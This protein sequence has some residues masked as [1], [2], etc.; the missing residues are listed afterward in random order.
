MR[1]Q[2]WDVLLFPE[3][4]HVPLKEFKTTCYAVQSSGN[5]EYSSS[6]YAGVHTVTPL[7][8]TFVPGIPMNHSFTISVHA[9]VPA[10][11]PEVNK[12]DQLHKRYKWQV[13]VLINGLCVS[14]QKI[15]AVVT[16][17]QVIN[18]GSPGH[19]Y[20]MPLRFPPF[21]RATG[22][23]REWDPAADVGR[24]KVELSAGYDMYDAGDW[25]FHKLATTA[26]F[27]FY[28]APMDHLEKVGIAW[29]SK[30]MFD[31]PLHIASPATPRSM[32]QDYGKPSDYHRRSVSH[33]SIGMSLSPSM[34]LPH[35][36]PPTPAYAH[37]LYQSFSQD[38]HSNYDLSSRSTSAHSNLGLSGAAESLSTGLKDSYTVGRT[39]QVEK[40]R[41]SSEQMSR[42][43]Q[44]LGPDQ[45]QQLTQSLTS[46][47]AMPPPPLPLHAINAK[48][49]RTDRRASFGQPEKY[50]LTEGKV[51]DYGNGHRGVCRSSDVSMHADCTHYPACMFEN[52]MGQILHSSPIML[53]TVIKGKKE[54]SSPN[55]PRDFM[56]TILTPTSPKAAQTPSA[57]H[58]S[59]TESSPANSTGRKHSRYALRDLPIDNGSPEKNVNQSG[60]K[61]TSRKVSRTSMSSDAS[62]ASRKAKG[63]S[64]VM[65]MHVNTDE[66]KENVMIVDA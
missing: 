61:S 8:T 2:D 65:G 16:W 31:N 47:Q 60:K 50:E 63:R 37:P 43:I 12:G 45:K 34:A 66:D 33:G 13:R 40:N 46:S 19:A 23:Q 30:Q 7:L 58:M 25:L 4:S 22:Q 21:A 51:T 28:P 38:A 18:N 1:Y 64:N 26:C 35:P 53:A 62:I 14:T 29:P 39:P 24:V 11:H 44:A 55:P 15:P 49:S 6:A 52:D 59:V 10:L 3:G 27:S 57:D 56:S 20:P 48:N 42:L 36:P 41:I 9:W 17:P 5:A 54:G 32:L